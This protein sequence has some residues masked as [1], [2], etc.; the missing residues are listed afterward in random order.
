MGTCNFCV[1]REP[2]ASPSSVELDGCSLNMTSWCLEW[3]LLC[4]LSSHPCH[5]SFYLHHALF[6]D[7]SHFHGIT[8]TLGQVPIQTPIFCSLW[9]PTSAVAAAKMSSLKTIF[10]DSAQ[11]ATFSMKPSPNGSEHS[12]PCKPIVIFSLFPLVENTSSTISVH[13]NYTHSLISCAHHII[14]LILRPSSTYN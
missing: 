3:I 1:A 12:F 8:D 4:H 13:S 6:S 5:L 9:S 2:L 7:S 14:Q 10:Q 11:I